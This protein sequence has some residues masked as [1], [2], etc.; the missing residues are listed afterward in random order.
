MKKNISI[1][2]VSVVLLSFFSTS[3]INFKAWNPPQLGYSYV[4]LPEQNI[5]LN[6]SIVIP[7]F[8]FLNSGVSLYKSK[9]DCHSWTS[10]G[11]SHPVIGRQV[12]IDNPE[13]VNLVNP[14]KITIK[15]TMLHRTKSHVAITFSGAV[16]SIDRFF[17]R[18]LTLAVFISVLSHTTLKITV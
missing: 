11:G 4:N 6:S 14:P 18:E 17:S 16:W 7:S 2:V 3:E 5:D 12:T 15:K 13:C 8:I 9:T 10:I 1:L